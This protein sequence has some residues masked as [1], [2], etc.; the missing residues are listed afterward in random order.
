MK[1][2]SKLL[3]TGWSRL[4]ALTGA[5]LLA[6]SSTHAQDLFI[7]DITLDW[8]PG[9][10]TLIDTEAQ[11]ASFLPDDPITYS[12]TYG[13][14]NP[15]QPPTSRQNFRVTIYLSTDGNPDNPNNFRLDWFDAY[16][17]GTFDGYAATLDTDP[18]EPNP[19]AARIRLE[20]TGRDQQPLPAFIRTRTYTVALPRNFT[21]TYFLVPVIRV[22]DGSAD[23]R[24]DNNVPFIGT[25]R[26]QIRSADSPTVE[27]VS[28]AA[29]GGDANE[30]SE[31]PS[32]SRDGR[33]VVF[34]SEATNL[35]TGFQ[36][37]VGVA[38]V[39]LRDNLTDTTT[40]ISQLGG[41]AGNQESRYPRI[42][43]DGRYVVFQSAA[44]NLIAGDTNQQTDIFL[45]QLATGV[46]TRISRPNPEVPGNVPGGNQQASGGSFMPSISADGWTVA[47]ESDARN[48]VAQPFA[49]TNNQR[50]IYV[51]RRSGN[52]TSTGASVQGRLFAASVTREGVFGDGASSQAAVSLDGQSV[53]FRSFAENLAT[54]NVGPH[55]GKEYEPVT[56]RTVDNRRL[57]EIYV[58]ELRFV[59]ELIGG[60]PLTDEYGYVVRA[61]FKR[62]LDWDPSPN[63]TR[64]LNRDAIEPA[65]S[66]DGRYVAFASRASNVY[67][68]PQHENFFFV[69][70]IY[71]LNRQVDL[72]RGRDEVG[73]TSLTLISR[74]PDDDFAQDD[75]LE[76]VISGDGRFVG[77]R[78]E[79]QNLQPAT[80]T[81]SDGVQFNT[82]Y[83]S[84]WDRPFTWG[85]LEPDE[86]SLIYSRATFGLQPISEFSDTNRRSDI[87]VR[88][89][90]VISVTVVDGGSGYSTTNPPPVNIVGGG[91]SGAQA[92]AVVQNGAVVRVDV[93][94]P[95][96]GYT[97]IPDV[98]IQGS[99]T[100]TANLT[101]AN[102]RVTLSKFG[103]ETLGL[104][105]NWA[106]PSS[107]SLEMSA[108][109]RYMVFASD[110]DNAR[111]FIFDK[112][113]LQPLDN[114][115]KRDV[116]MV[117][118]RVG[119]VLSPGQGV[120]PLVNVLMNN[121][122]ATFN[123]NRVI[124]VQAFDG[125]STVMP[126]GQIRSL[127]IFANDVELGNVRRT[128]MNTQSAVAW[129]NWT[130]PTVAGNY[131]IYAVAEDDDGNR[132]ISTPQLVQVLPP[133]SLPPQVAVTVSPG[134]ITLGETV[135]IRAFPSDPDNGVSY[136]RFFSNGTQIGLEVSPPWQ[137]SYTPSAAQTYEIVAVVHDG[138]PPED[139][140]PP[141]LPLRNSVLSST[142]TLQVLPLPAPQIEI[143]R[144]SAGEIV[145][146][147]VGEPVF[148][149]LQAV[150]SN[151]AASISA[152][153]LQIG[154]Q[155]VQANRVG[156]TSNYRVE[157][158]PTAADIGTVTVN[159]RATDSQ[160]ASGVSG[161]RQVLVNP[162][163]G[164]APNVEILSPTANATSFT[165]INLPVEISAS[166][167]GG[168]NRVE[169]YANGLFIGQAGV[170]AGT[171]RATIGLDLSRLGA[172]QHTLIAVAH[173]NNNNIRGSTPV[174]IVV[175]TPPPQ[176]AILEPGVD[177]VTGEVAIRTGDRVRMVIDARSPDPL[178]TITDVSITSN[179]STIGTATRVPNTYTYVYEFRPTATG[180]YEVGV[181][182]T[183]STGGTRL[184]P[185]ITFRVTESLAPRPTVVMISP[186]VGSD[187]DDAIV[188]TDRS[189]WPFVAFAVAGQ[190]QIESVRF[191]MLRVV[192]V[193]D[194]GPPPSGG[195]LM[196]GQVRQ[197]PHDAWRLDYD[198]AANDITPGLYVVTA[199]AQDNQ[200]SRAVSAP[201]AVRVLPGSG[202][203]PSVTLRSSRSE[204]MVDESVRFTA[205]AAAVQ[206]RIEEVFLFSNGVLAQI[207]DSAN[208]QTSAPFVWDGE[209]FTAGVWDMYSVARDSFGHTSISNTV[210]VVVRPAGG[211]ESPADPVNRRAFV[212]QLYEDLLL[213]TPTSTVLQFYVNA[214]ENGT[215]TRAEVVQRLM[216]LQ[217][218]EVVQWVIATYI[219]VLGEYPTLLQLEEGVE[220]LRAGGG[221]Q[222]G[223]GE[224]NVPP[225]NGQPTNGIPLNTPTGLQQLVFQLLDS[226]QFVIKYLRPSSQ[227]SAADLFDLIWQTH[228]GRTH[229]G[230][231]RRT[232]YVNAMTNNRVGTVTRLVIENYNGLVPD[233]RRAA[234]V[235]LLLRPNQ[236]P[237][238]H[239]VTVEQVR[240][241]GTLP[242]WIEFILNRDAYAARFN[243]GGNFFGADEGGFVTRVSPWLGEFNDTYFEY[244]AKRGWI[245]HRE[246]GWLYAGGSG[247]GQGIWFWD[248]TQQD[249]LW[250]RADLYPFMYSNNRGHWMFYNL[251]GTPERRSFYLYTPLNPRWITVP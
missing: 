79:S 128:G 157:W 227:F 228:L 180:L 31:A 189:Q 249:W 104:V 146:G 240:F 81:R 245:R 159:A 147:T 107:R 142:Q 171:G 57:S 120:L 88:D 23:P 197:M 8:D 33:Y 35:V 122:P 182:A 244:G 215:L 108:D 17:A 55:G 94:T 100:A 138:P 41:A 102:Q 32:V 166:D 46:L 4:L 194:D 89:T 125:G 60:L 11:I 236:D 198:F 62:E 195:L 185:T 7:R 51:F 69:S 40:L 14:N 151:P 208:P 229:P 153:V 10:S 220:F 27:R 187:L 63:P 222:P 78:T 181:N 80:V 82:F 34:H 12:V 28:S 235:L 167:D 47:F 111:S 248:H 90:G 173:D 169:L 71:L 183:D 178:I 58:K 26:I 219:T 251:G 3:K 118:Q 206:G 44:T 214:L 117:D 52:P 226:E 54:Q 67:P 18:D 24:A 199:V 131:Q 109:G 66:A 165:H 211:L 247:F 250:T 144:P 95:G 20:E 36:F 148:F 241:L 135:T 91:G 39:Y 106:I 21:G 114:N 110:A 97:F 140:P 9:A 86:A 136:V 212:A 163:I 61:S 192:S 53:A 239:T 38:Q 134:T 196:Q 179:D 22:T 48:L 161:G 56:R 84:A 105:D 16:G 237:D 6:A 83:R 204:V 149:E 141:P 65:I 156:L 209:I 202:T 143:L 137:I 2:F 158:R 101:E 1:N 170:N 216:A 139:V 75:A 37:P 230:N 123:S 223:T 124:R 145:R 224:P 200:G 126:Q 64:E 172:G 132:V 98:F 19:A 213:G 242:N 72:A 133:N 174:T 233:A 225:T 115:R 218:F 92:V 116:F 207:E 103:E 160:G 113:N 188:L 162:V 246:H 193:D 177:P 96:S 30:L 77:F 168:V 164:T 59:G 68:F 243:G 43:A 203:R 205:T 112:S 76:P 234:L 175:S 74:G 152:V 184:T 210:R 190:R 150:T 87:Y 232:E 129:V 186:D 155:S 42:S 119:E 191:Y 154:N 70:Q 93:T 5:G 121:H 25:A 176:V 238:D 217:S 13:R 49:D 130:V 85:A 99:A 201:V 127:R 50:D 231:T 221:E 73:N 15:G 45:Y 29:G